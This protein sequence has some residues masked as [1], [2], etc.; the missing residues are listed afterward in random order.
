MQPI[1][2]SDQTQ[3]EPLKPLTPQQIDQLM[4]LLDEWSADESGYEEE[5]WDDL[6]N[7]ICSA[8]TARVDSNQS[9]A[10]TGI[11]AEL[12]EHP[13]TVQNFEPLT[14]EEAHDRRR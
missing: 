2:Q 7:A 8:V 1:Q 3:R 12:I 13:V 6:K 14:R 5:T 9:T 11:I 10:K 4:A